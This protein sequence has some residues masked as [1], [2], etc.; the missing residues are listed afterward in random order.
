MRAGLIAIASRNYGVDAAEQTIDFFLK[1]RDKLIGLDLAGNEREFPCRLFENAFRRAKKA[2]ARITIHAGEDSGPE[3]MWEAIELLGAE[4]IGHGL[5]SVEDPTLLEHLA[6]NR[7]CL[8]M[9]PSSNWITQATRRLESHP[10]PRVL[11]AGVPVSINTDDPG[12][13]AV[14][15]PHELKVARE[16]IGLTQAQIDECMRHAERASFLT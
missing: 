3:N 14:T 11:E 5:S 1:N 16:K 6:K 13:F 2:G 9:C 8:E 4:R 12:I 10:L 7:I 15:L